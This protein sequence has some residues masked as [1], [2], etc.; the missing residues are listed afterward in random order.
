MSDFKKLFKPLGLNDSEIAIY[1]LSLEIGPA[2]PQALAKNSGFSRPATYQAIE[3][4]VNKGLMSFVL[5]GKR[6]VY[7]AEPPERLLHFGQTRLKELEIKIK[8]IA[9]NIEELN[10]LRKGDKPTI[11]FF[12][13]ANGIKSILSDL[14]ASEPEMTYEITNVNAVK[15]VFTYNDLESAHKIMEKARGK[16][17]AFLAGDIKAVREGVDAR[18][19]PKEKFAFEGDVLVYGDKTALASYKGKVVGVVIENKGIAQTMKALFDI[20]W[21]SSDKFK[22]LD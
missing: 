11:K 2:Q 6:N 8:E 13:G 15:N 16:G 5:K 10:A 12:E 17:R 18:H 21:Q 3:Q 1:L 20:A 9:E 22:K 14:V 19:L 4:L 7:A